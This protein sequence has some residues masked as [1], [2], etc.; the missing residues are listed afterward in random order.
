MED[1]NLT[2]DKVFSISEF[3]SLLNIGLKRSKVKIIGEVSEVKIGPTGHVYFSLKD[4]KDQSVIS[5]I[6][7]KFRYFT[8]GIELRE[9]VKIMAY[10]NPEVYAPSGRLSFIA[11]TI[12]LAGEGEL[13]KE[14]ER[15]KKKLEQEGAFAEAR[16]RPVPLYPQNIGVITS[17][18][19]AVIA[20]FSNNLKKFGFK[21][22]MI[23]SRVEGQTAVEDLLLSIKT[24]KKEDIDVLVIMRGGGSLESMMAFNNELLVREVINF[25]VPVIAGI[26]HHKD[27]P[28]VAL[29]ADIS[30]ST[31]TAAANL[32]NESWQEAE[33]SLENYRRNI[34]EGYKNT[35]LNIKTKVDRALE[36]S[37][38]GFKMLL[39]RI[40]QIIEL[41]EKAIE[42]NN[43][44]RQLNLGYS[45]SMANGKIIRRTSDVKIGENIDL[46]I[47][48]GIIISEVKKI[49]NQNGK[50]KN[51]QQKFEL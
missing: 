24:F 51:R 10:G 11:E 35:L 41:A 18:K 2:G 28:L 19:G 16:K 20:D 42:L 37:L 6:I 15:L 31:P 22:K 7:W 43:P 49:N 44:E 21:V 29:A 46:R 1:L 26:G 12:E 3:I 23:D 50:G 25:K 33:M 45:I 39:S 14:Y 40:K 9:G 27:Q 34:V 32:L 5:C 47:L 8:F 13:K 17:L 36:T 4:E 48:D 38:F 30:V